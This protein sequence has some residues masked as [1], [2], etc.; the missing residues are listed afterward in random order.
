MNLFNKKKTKLE[1]TNEFN[2]VVVGNS[3]TKD[4]WRRLKKNKMAV[5]SVVI[6]SIYILLAILAPI[7]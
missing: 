7:L 3:L 5:I 1:A 4:A 6:V 2:Q